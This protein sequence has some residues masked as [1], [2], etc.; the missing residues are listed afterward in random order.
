V[1]TEA[2][3]GVTDAL[4]SASSMSAESGWVRVLS[5]AAARDC[6]QGV[7]SQPGAGA[8]PRTLRNWSIRLTDW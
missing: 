1:P 4:Y 2:R 8:R 5:R 3:R 6:A 7:A